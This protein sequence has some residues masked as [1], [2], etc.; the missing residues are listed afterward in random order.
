MTAAKEGYPH[1]HRDNTGG[2]GSECKP[3]GTA[4]LG[5]ELTGRAAGLGGARLGWAGCCAMHL[6][7]F[8]D[9]GEARVLPGEKKALLNRVASDL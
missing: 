6:L 1:R 9:V 3:R 5:A 7:W 4:A 2:G 8:V